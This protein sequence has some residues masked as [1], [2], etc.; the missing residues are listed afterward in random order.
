MVSVVAGG[1]ITLHSEQRPTLAMLVLVV[2][3][4]K[5]AAPVVVVVA[6]ALL[7]GGIG[8]V[9][10]KGAEVVEA[11]G[12]LGVLQAV[13]DI[14]L[15]LVDGL[16]GGSNVVLFSIKLSELLSCVAVAVEVGGQSQ[17]DWP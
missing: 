3:D 17:S 8:V 15:L 9:V 1:N 14:P 4:R 13:T 6:A 2:G 16:D 7:E 12:G 10:D 5:G 11:R